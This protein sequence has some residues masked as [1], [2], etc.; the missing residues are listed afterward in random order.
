MHRGG[1]SW[2]WARLR[3]SAG[4]AELVR[5]ERVLAAEG[6]SPTAFEQTRARELRLLAEAAER[7]RAPS[8]DLANRTIVVVDDGLATG[9]TM[10]AA[11]AAARTAR[12]ARVVA[13]VPV[14]SR[15]A[16]AEIEVLADEVVCPLVPPDF[17]AVSEWF[18]DFGQTSD[19]EVV[20]LL[21]GG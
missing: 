2:P 21:A 11:I 1:R 14:A 19:D 13:A 4:V 3:R 10:A 8:F 7:Y 16:L 9:M 18:D 15:Q 12:P 6:V 20:R 17:Y 5:Y